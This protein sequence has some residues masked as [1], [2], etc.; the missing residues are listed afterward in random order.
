MN[1]KEEITKPERSMMSPFCEAMMNACEK[2][3]ELRTPS[4]TSMVLCTD[5]NI[6]EVKQCG[7]YSDM[8]RMLY[9]S[10][11]HD[12]KF[13]ELIMEASLLYSKHVLGNKVPTFPTIIKPIN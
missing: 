8:L 11:R 13:A 12:E 6:L 5:G 10:M 9:T 3:D 4:D 2:V 7:S 1:E